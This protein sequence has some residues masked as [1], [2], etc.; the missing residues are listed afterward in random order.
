MLTRA[1]QRHNGARRALYGRADPGLTERSVQSRD[2]KLL[3]AVRQI[4][5][6]AFHTSICVARREKRF[7]G[8]VSVDGLLVDRSKI[9]HECKF[10]DGTFC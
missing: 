6:L 10:A 9:V 1:A 8:T 7:F 4:I 3:G 5:N 2:C